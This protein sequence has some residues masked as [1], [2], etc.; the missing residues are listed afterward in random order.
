MGDKDDPKKGTNMTP[1]FLDGISPAGAKV[2]QGGGGFGGK[3]GGK[4]F[5]PKGKGGAFG[6]RGGL[7][8]Q[9]RRKALAEQITSKDNPWFAAAFV[10]RM[11]GEFM[12]QS[13]YS[14]IDDL[15]P[16]KDAMMP[17]VLARVSASFRG[18][19]YDIKQV[20]RDIMNSDTY[21]RQ[22]RPGES[23]DEHQLFATHNPVRMNGNAL[24]QS[25]TGTLGPIGGGFGGKGGFG[26]FGGRGGFG[27]LE[28]QFKSEFSYDPS[29]KAEEI[30][31][32][33]AQALILM[34][35]PQINQKIKA[36]PT[37][38]LGRILA[39]YSDNDE[40]LRVVYLRTLA[41]RPTDRET[42]RL[43]EHI[44]SVK[45]RAEAFED[46]LWA[47]VNSTEFQMKR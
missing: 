22:I 15:G 39:T 38:V 16:Q 27:G 43:R 33:I 21:Q 4:G 8:D 1:K 24:W 31:G 44:R 37:N 17:V 9:S 26:G 28:Q 34:N 40:A 6:A 2:A 5:Q 35:N 32:S 14:P 41:R 25:L 18:N 3:F 36:S 30:E 7:D 10:N 11:W 46:I 47:L 42:T 19:G 20:I 23:G 12:G 45:N 13:F 29:T